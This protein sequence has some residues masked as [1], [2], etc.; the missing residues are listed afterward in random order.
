MKIYHY[1]YV[2]YGNR[3]RIIMNENEECKQICVN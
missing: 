1:E 2:I 3:R